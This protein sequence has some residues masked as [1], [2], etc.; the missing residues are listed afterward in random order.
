MLIICRE[1]IYIP[2]EALCC[3]PL[4]MMSLMAGRQKGVLKVRLFHIYDLCVLLSCCRTHLLPH[5]WWLTPPREASPQ[6]RWNASVVKLLKAAALFS[7]NNRKETICNDTVSL[8]Q[9]EGKLV[10]N[11]TFTCT[12]FNFI[13]KRSDADWRAFMSTPMSCLRGVL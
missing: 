7:P 3:V 12:L 13:I 10:K 5:R 2:S 4:L 9:S 8:Q 1:N 6:E 11:A